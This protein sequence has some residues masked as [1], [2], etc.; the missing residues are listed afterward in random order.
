MFRKLK[1]V[2]LLAVFGLAASVTKAQLPSS[3]VWGEQ[4]ISSSQTVTLTG[5]ISLQGCIT[6]SG[7]GTVLT[8]KNTGASKNIFN[9]KPIDQGELN[10]L[11]YVTGGATLII[12]GGT[13]G[14]IIGGGASYE[15]ANFVFDE[16]GYINDENSFGTPIRTMSDAAIVNHNGTLRLS[17]LTI[18]NVCNTNTNPNTGTGTIAHKDGTTEITNCT[19]TKCKQ[20]TGAG[21]FARPNSTGNVTIKNTKFEYCINFLNVHG[22]H[23]GTIRGWG[24]SHVDLTLE[25]VEV[26]QSFSR[27]DAA[28]L[29][30]PANG[31][32]ESGDHYATLTIDG[33]KFHKNKATDNAGALD[34]CGTVKFV[35][36]LTKVYDNKARTFGGGISIRPYN[37]G[38]PAHE[39]L[40]VVYDITDKLEVY[41]NTAKRGGGIAFFSEV[42]TNTGYPTTLP[43]GTSFEINLK[44]A[45]IHHNHATDESIGNGGGMWLTNNYEGT[46]FSFTFNLNKGFVYENTAKAHGGGIYLMGWKI[47]SSAEPGDVVEIYKNSAEA[48]GGGMYINS[49]TDYT[50]NSGKIYDNTTQTGGGGVYMKSGDFA[51]NNGEISSNEAKNNGGGLYLEEGNVTISN[52]T[53]SGNTANTKNGGGFYVLNGTVN[54][55][56][57][58][59]ESDK[60]EISSNS[61]RN[62]GGFYA[63]NGDVTITG[64]LIFGNSASVN[65]GGFYSNGGTINLTDGT[66]GK[67]GEANQA[68]NGGGVYANGGE[69]NISNG[70]IQYNTATNGAGLYMQGTNAENKAIANF[71]NGSF[72]GNTAT[73]AGGGI[74]LADYSKLN[75]SGASAIT[76]NRVGEGGKGGGV[77]KS[78]ETTSEIMVGGNS[79]KIDGNWAGNAGSSYSEATRNN[80]FLDKYDD[81][82]T[83]DPAA[84]IEGTV[85][86]GIS[87]DGTAQDALPTRVIRCTSF[88]I[89]NSIFNKLKEAYTQGSKDED[90][91]KIYDDASKYEPLF[92]G[93]PDPYT[94]EYIFFVRTWSSEIPEVPSNF[95]LGQIDDPYELT[96]FMMVANDIRCD[97]WKREHQTIQ[98]DEIE[99]EVIADIDMAGRIWIPIGGMIENAAAV[100]FKGKLKGNGHAII[101]LETIGMINYDRYGVFGLTD[102]AE[103]RDLSL[104]DCKITA[105]EATAIGLLIGEMKGGSVSNVTAGGIVEASGSGENANAVVGGLI[106]MT[107]GSAKVLNCVV[108]AEVDATFMPEEIANN[109]KNDSR[110]AGGMVGV[111]NG[112]I[113]NC[114][115][116]PKIIHGSWT[117]KFVGGMVGENY[118]TFTNCYVRL[119]RGVELNQPYNGTESGY[120][121]ADNHSLF[122]M[123]AGKNSGTIEYCYYPEES[124]RSIMVGS[125]STPNQPLVNAG[126]N[127]TSHGEYNTTVT[128]YYY[129]HNDNLVTKIN[130]ATVETPASLLSKLN[131]WVDGPHSSKDGE[132]ATYSHWMRTCASPINGDYP[133]LEYDN[134]AG[135]MGYT[136]IAS[137]DGIN[138][139]YNKSLNT[140][141]GKYNTNGSALFV[142]NTPAEEINKSTA[143]PLYVGED[144][145]LQLKPGTAITNAYVGITLDNSKS[146]TVGN[147][148]GNQFNWHMFSTPL[149]A[150]PLGVNY[151]DNHTSYNYWNSQDIPDFGFYP[152]G[153]ALHGYFP[154]KTFGTDGTDGVPYYAEWDYYTYLEPH[155]H[156]INFKRNSESHYHQDTDN[157]QYPNHSQIVYANET[158]LVK[159]KGYLL[160]T[161][162]E[163]YLQCNGTLNSGE[164]S[165]ALDYTE[166]NH[167]VYRGCNLLG[168][169]YQ[170]YLNFDETG[171]GS[172]A[173]LDEDLGG[174]VAYTKGASRNAYPTLSKEG[175]EITAPGKYIHMHQG[176][177]VVASASGQGVTFTPSMCTN[178]AD[179]SFRGEEQPAYPL[180]NLAVTEADG[181]REFVTIELDRP[182][183]GGAVKMK[184][185]RNGSSLIYT[186]VDGE[187]YSIA[188]MPVGTTTAAVRFETLDEGTFTMNWNTQNGAFSYLH[189]I[190]NKTGMDID[191]LASGEYRFKASPEDYASRFKLVFS[192]TGVEEAEAEAEDFAFLMNGILVINGE[193][194]ADIFDLT[195]RLVSST[196]LTGSQNTLSLPALTQGL[197]MIRL[198]NGNGSKVQKI[199]IK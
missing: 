111:N 59:E 187:D 185:L 8:I 176:F 81:F 140:M 143:I 128:P 171:L 165:I 148:T 102:G 152:E 83:V 23:G 3:G 181:S 151:Q 75:M 72:T 53:I 51:M 57:G 22:T 1:L 164:V 108:T 183:N 79:L 126:S 45:S 73:T 160:A 168:N 124:L 56:K 82:L 121:S 186:H 188:F 55:I 150:A 74:Y 169:P 69:V 146:K 100:P 199:V 178:L 130:G 91:S 36:N 62:G 122:G 42:D 49:G 196:R 167:P 48:S 11:F 84:G 78:G 33:C 193:G 14:I 61:A 7:N 93:R 135:T 92:A 182:D 114:F 67:S 86:V 98:P 47:V 103:I 18:Q 37:S 161:K 144:A 177:F 138:M 170:S 118:G 191:C 194:T 172:Y 119:E 131:E 189:L 89:L 46:D 158:E 147:E 101:G 133:V 173:I 104:V 179:G 123:F 174:Y 58:E 87:I 96:Y 28:A 120:V 32:H 99:G 34:L 65:G 110:T 13:N 44:G 21:V 29:Y 31:K 26:S 149:A 97:E 9:E 180:V 94:F 105:G 142:Y 71:S 68:V 125:T 12:D 162:E 27:V 50:M 10:H 85:L 137:R 166:D 17:N 66:I 90:L 30:W 77:Y 163:T 117:E 116:N 136:T 192:Y 38:D 80:V 156:W 159:G 76:G 153:N 107:D 15:V 190:D 132:A 52:G 5:K 16:D 41:N 106:G 54:L 88:E 60:I 141:I 198:S 25:N 6:V 184:G 70:Y 113:A 39:A 129:K 63:N 112:I 35:N 20:Y 175:G 145:A 95:N 24:D 157:P 4:T 43:V 197:Y 40:N 195:G 109:Y 64:A 154:S 134:L 19:I 127:P 2:M 139:E 155:Y 115:A